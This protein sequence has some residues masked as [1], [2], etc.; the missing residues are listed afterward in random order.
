MPTLSWLDAAGF[1]GVLLILAAYAGVQL[2]RL[3]PLGARAQ[4]LNLAG[5]ALILASLVRA[6]NLAAFVMEAAWA[7]LAAYG[8]ARRLWRR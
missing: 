7:A 3:D 8:L 5:A 6:F 2:R 1:L 4:L